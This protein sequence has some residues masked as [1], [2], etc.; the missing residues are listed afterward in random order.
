MWL[1]EALLEVLHSADLP[2][3]QGMIIDFDP[4]IVFLSQILTC[5]FLSLYGELRT[6]QDAASANR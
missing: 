4:I 2:G 3:R 5:A 1:V 6:H